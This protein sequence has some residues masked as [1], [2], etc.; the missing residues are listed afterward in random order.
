MEK[1]ITCAR[2]ARACAHT[3]LGERKI[4]RKREREREREKLLVLYVYVYVCVCV[5]VCVCMFVCVLASRVYSY[6]CTYE[7]EREKVWEEG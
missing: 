6:G 2:G 3:H 7:K 5:C 1:E 4:E